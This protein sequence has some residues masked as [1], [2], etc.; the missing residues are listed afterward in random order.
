MKINTTPRIISW[1]TTF[2]CNLKCEHCYISAKS[3]K[4]K[5]ELTTKEGFRLIDQISG[6]SKPIF[7]LSGGEP[8]LREDIFELASYGTKKGLRVVMGTNGI[9][10]NNKIAKKLADSGIKRI[11]IS[12]DSLN[13]KIHDTIR[14]VNEAYENTIKGIKVCK[15]N[16]L[17][18]QI[19]TTV[20]RQNYSEIFK[21]IKFAEKLGADDFHLFFLVP[22]GR[23]ENVTDITPFQYEKLLIDLYNKKH[24]FKINVKPTCAPQ[25]M[26]IAKMKA[27]NA[28]KYVRGCLAGITYCRINP[29][30]EVNPCPYLPI[31]AGNVKEESFEKIWKESTVFQELRNYDNLKGK[32]GICEYKDICGGCRARAYAITKDYLEEEMWCV[33]KPRG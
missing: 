1:N 4:V 19:N 3:Q 23:G 32:C 26:R 5:E 8:L 20:T 17:S 22:T 25:F 30:G 13:P 2:K 27:G 28:K 12:L 9:R 29:I 18:F 24:E 11:A 15:K 21:I 31:Y 14:G 16:N 10:I 33:Y 6:F 7:V